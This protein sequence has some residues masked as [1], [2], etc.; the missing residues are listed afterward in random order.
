MP[1]DQD[2]AKLIVLGWQ[3]LKTWGKKSS[4]VCFSCGAPHRLVEQGSDCEQQEEQCLNAV[5]VNELMACK[6]VTPGYRCDRLGHWDQVSTH[7]DTST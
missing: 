5:E 1:K 6:C 7:T 3:G 2:D 4:K